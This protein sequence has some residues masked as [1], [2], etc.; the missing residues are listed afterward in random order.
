MQEGLANICLITEFRTVLKI[1]IESVIPKKMDGS[2][3]QNAG[4]RR[5]FEKTLTNLTRTLDFS[6]PR[7]LLLASPGFVATDFKAYIQK[8]GQEKTDKVLL[9][10]ARSATVV[11]SNT[12]HLHSLNEI[13]KSP[14]V[15]SQM[16]DMKFAREARYIDQ[17]FEK[18]KRDDGTAWYGT[19]AVEKAVADGAV[20]PGGGLLLLN[21]SLFR[22]EDLAVRKRYVALVDAVQAGGGEARILSSDHESGQRLRMIGDVAA[23]L[24]YPMMDLD[25][26]EEDEQGG[27]VQNGGIRHRDEEMD[28]DMLQSVI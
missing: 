19:R 3:E 8:Q 16:K 23:V 2:S 22:N 17:F 24:N 20:G 15:L 25:E 12:G 7:P 14:E 5:F 10:V 27:E 1:K 28:A 26:D 4:M 21:N 11:H 6:K 18:L 13:L 9:E